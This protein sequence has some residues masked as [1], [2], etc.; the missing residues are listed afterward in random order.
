MKTVKVEIL[1]GFRGCQLEDMLS[2]YL[3]SDFAIL[4]SEIKW[5]CGLLYGVVLFVKEEE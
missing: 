4:N 2:E 3:N 5:D 1:N